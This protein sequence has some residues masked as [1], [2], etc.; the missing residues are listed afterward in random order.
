M[1]R[2]HSYSS[3]HKSFYR[4][5]G[6]EFVPQVSLEDGLAA[7]EM[8]MKAQ[9]NI[10]NKAEEE[11]LTKPLIAFSSKS[12]EHLLNLAIDVANISITPPQS[13]HKHEYGRHVGEEKEV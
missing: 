9:Q 6:G 8:G 2:F 11:T 5:N 1:C 13:E 10:S 7:V 4:Q 12:S 3:Y